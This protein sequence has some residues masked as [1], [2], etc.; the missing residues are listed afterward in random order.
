MPVQIVNEFDTTDIKDA[1]I[2]FLNA[3]GTQEPGASFGCV[4]TLSGEPEA[5]TIEKKCGK[6]TLKTKTKTSKLNMT[7]SA[8]IPLKVAR[9]YFGMTNEK[10]KT[11]I[12]AAGT[13]T[14]GKDFVLTVTAVDDF[15]ENEKLIA[16][17]NA[18]NT[19]GFKV[20]QIEAG[21]EEVAMLELQFSALP[22][23]LNYFY[24]EAIVSDLEDDT[25][26]EK[27]H[28]EFNTELV[29]AVATP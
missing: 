5:I 17:P 18:S 21:A 9:D 26:A 10:L 14:K 7:V 28:T 27:W 3:D 15:G 24:Y 25:V 8:H 12:W 2:Q 19:S 1:S 20:Q 4:G 6:R 29:E 23:D 13:L 16:F 11:G 22:D